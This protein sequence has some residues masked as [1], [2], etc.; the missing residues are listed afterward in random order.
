MTFLKKLNM[1]NTS[2][3]VKKTYILQLYDKVVAFIK[4][5]DLWQRKVTKK[6]TVKPII[7]CFL[8]MFYKIMIL[9]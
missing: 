4:K 5:I 3:Q 8:K 1:L 9:N 6:K 7:F 2:L